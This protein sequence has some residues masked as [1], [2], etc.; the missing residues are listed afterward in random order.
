MEIVIVQNDGEWQVWTP[1]LTGA[2][3][4]SGASR[5]QAMADAVR[6][7]EAACDLLIGARTS[8]FTPRTSKGA[9]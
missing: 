5:T 8:P 4:G 1:D 2:C 6:N 3:I 7:M 9:A